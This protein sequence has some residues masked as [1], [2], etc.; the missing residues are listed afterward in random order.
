MD[1]EQKNL[2]GEQEEIKEKMDDHQQAKDVDNYFK[3]KK[4]HAVL[5][6]FLLVFFTAGITAFALSFG[7]EKVVEKIQVPVE[8]TEFSKLYQAYDLIQE[9]YFEDVDKEALIDG[10]IDGMVKALGDPYSEYMTAEESEKFFEG[11]SSSFEGIGAHVEQRNDQVVIVA[12]IKGSPA[13][14]A[15]LKPNDVILEVDGKSIQGMNVHEAV[16]L[17]RGEKGTKVVLTI[18]RPGIDQPIKVEIIRD[19]IPIETVYSEML[20]EGIGK[21]QISSFAERT[22]EELQAAIAELKE[23]GMKGLILD[24]RQNPGGLLEQAI[25]ISSLFVPEGEVI[26]QMEFY[27][28]SRQRQLSNQKEPFDLPLVIVVDGGSASASE[29]LAAAAKESAGVPIVGEKTFGKGTAQN[30]KRFADGSNL[31]LTMAK[32]LTPS[33]EWINEKGIT[34]DYI[35][36]LPEWAYLPFIDPDMELKENMIADE[37]HIAEQMLVVLGYEISSVDSYFTEETTAA[38]STFQADHE[39]DVTGV[40]QGETTMKIMESLRDKLEKEDPQIQKAKEVLKE[41]ME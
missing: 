25:E 37:V 9:T 10:A 40:I 23:Q 16:Q 11:L 34:P 21:I 17:I 39:L 18:E 41:L 14:K 28:G 29:I 13:E 15:G 26:Y 5:I 22:Y 12:P 19:V 32:W 38:V 4:F 27:D 30:A 33:G 2:D 3:I 31:K 8:R 24:L 36:P 35:V 1:L 6:L 20:E 7:D